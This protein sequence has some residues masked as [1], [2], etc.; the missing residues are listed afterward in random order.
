[1]ES[2]VISMTGRKFEGMG[3]NMNNHTIRMATLEDAS[4]IQEIYEPYVLNTSIT[5]EYEPVSLEEFRVRM[6]NILKEF[7]WLVYELDGKVVGYAYCSR[8]K[9]R[10]AFDWDCECSVYIDMAYHR[11]GIASAL[12]KELFD[13]IEAQGYYTV[14]SLITASHASSIE[15]HK[16]F[17]FKEICLYP[18]TG[19]KLGEWWDLLVMEKRLREVE[20][21][22]Q[23]PKSIHQIKNK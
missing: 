20:T 14:Y 5:F 6:A 8:F 18:R 21:V 7:P 1:M 3:I 13:Y 16:R 11:R 15:L 12:Y 19:Y 10:A 2:I 22:P 9:E 4:E 23:R 17:G